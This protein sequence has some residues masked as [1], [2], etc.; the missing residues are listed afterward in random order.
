MDFDGLG[1]K[2]FSDI[3]LISVLISLELFIKKTQMPVS[4]Y[5]DKYQFLNSHPAISIIKVL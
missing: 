4:C 2:L 3:L 5:A 1:A